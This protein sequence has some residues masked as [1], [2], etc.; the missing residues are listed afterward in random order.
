MAPTVIFYDLETTGANR[1]NQ[2]RDVQ[3]VSIGAINGKTGEEYHEYMVPTCDIDP[4]AS[5][6]NGIV[7]SEGE[8]FLKGVKIQAGQPKEVLQRFMDW[9]DRQNYDYLVAHGN[10]YFDSVVLR[11]NLARFGVDGRV[12][13]SRN[14]DSWDF[15]KDL[16]NSKQFYFQGYFLY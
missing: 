2:H 6:V 11:K 10:R 3:I 9:L 16:R 1:S 14:K 8:L 5:E 7:K 4:Q 12:R 13:V 15:M